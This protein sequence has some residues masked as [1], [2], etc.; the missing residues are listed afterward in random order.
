MISARND[1]ADL[2]DITN[3]LHPKKLETPA[4]IEKDST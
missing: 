3:T 4:N 1:Q 2:E